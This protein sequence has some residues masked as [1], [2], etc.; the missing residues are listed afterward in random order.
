MITKPVL[1]RREYRQTSS[2]RCAI[3]SDASSVMSLLG[4]DLPLNIGHHTV[5]IFR[6]N[7]TYSRVQVSIAPFYRLEKNTAHQ[8]SVPCL[9][10][11]PPVTRR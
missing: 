8:L 4:I 11:V 2:I 1:T 5:D 7:R 3:S 9:L 10:H 6:Q